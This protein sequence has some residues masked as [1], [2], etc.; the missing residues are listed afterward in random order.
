[1]AKISVVTIERQYCSGGRDIGKLVAKE[2]GVKCYDSEIMEMAA[3]RIGLSPEEIKNFEEA[4]MSPLKAPLSLRTGIDRKLNLPEKIFAAEAEII[5]E[6]AKKGPC[7]MVGRC[8]DYILKNVVP[9]LSV[10]IYASHENRVN[11][12]ME[13]HGIAYEDVESVL[14]RFDKKRADFYNINTTKNWSSM[15]T[16]DMC[17]NSGKLGYQGCARIIVETVR[18]SKGKAEQNGEC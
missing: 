6:I 18:A 5:T 2:L 3:E 1:M 16:Y 7:V 17:L 15:Q 4:V 14:K 10:F 8:A 13:A 12:A 11:H 9:T